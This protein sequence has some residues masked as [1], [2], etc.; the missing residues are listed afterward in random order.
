AGRRGGRGQQSL[1]SVGGA[2]PGR[3]GDDPQGGVRG[4]LLVDHTSG[5][6]AAGRPGRDALGTDGRDDR[7]IGLHVA[8]GHREWLRSAAGTVRT[9]NFV[10]NSNGHWRSWTL[11]EVVACV[12]EVETLVGQGEVGNDGVG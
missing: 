7:T 11:L 10:I 2:A 3:F 8:R 6:G 1:A 4:V 9:R 5:D 12:G